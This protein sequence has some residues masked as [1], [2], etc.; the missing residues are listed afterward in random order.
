MGSGRGIR[1]LGRKWAE[2]LAGALGGGYIRV[3]GAC[4]L[5]G[6]VNDGNVRGLMEESGGVHGLYFD[7]AMV[8]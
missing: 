3:T 5:R 6:W 2:S 7:Y 8:K 4:H 1:G